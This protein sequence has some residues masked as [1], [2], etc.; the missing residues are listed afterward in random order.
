M[1]PNQI[2]FAGATLLTI[3][4]IA[5]ARQSSA[6]EDGHE[7]VVRTVD[8]GSNINPNDK[9]P[10]VR[11]ELGP[12]VP[13][14]WVRPGFK[15]STAIK[16][17]PGVRFLAFDDRGILY[18]SRPDEGDVIAFQA[19][20][21]GSYGQLGVFVSHR[22]KVQMLQFVN[23]WMWF[24]TSTGVSRAKTDSKGR[25]IDE[26]DIVPDGSLPGGSGHWWRSLFVTS[27]GFYTS[28]GDV[29]NITDMTNSPR[30][31]IWKYSLDGKQRQLWS[32]GIRNT[33]KLLYRPGTTEL[34]GC[35]QGSD[36]FGKAYG[37]R[38][39]Q[40]PITDYNPPDEFN[41]YVK[42][43][44][45][46]HP[47]VVGFLTPR[48]EYAD[49]ADIDQIAARTIPPEWGLGAHVAAD[50]WC[51]VEKAGQLPQDFVG[52]ALIAEHGSWNHTHK[53]GYRIERVLFDKVTGFPFGS[54]IL[55][56]CIT[57]NDQ[58]LARPV[59]VE[60]APDGSLLFT[61]DSDGR[62]Y[63]ISHA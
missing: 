23:G 42:G 51:F 28:V 37:D 16:G 29:G 14:F 7:R 47:F 2:V 15:V 57:D 8:V 52:D 46:G 21:D 22:P 39:G 54:Q 44:F 56:S 6:P 3:S 13:P 55:V 61:S 60:M 5:C 50:S 58:V 33:E 18:V 59:D 53:V 1:K 24:A 62:I 49:R 30:E 9:L 43:G 31:K 35:D 48:P 20:Q 32:S 19:N 40:Q 25:A 17:V 41:R 11:G 45:Y 36:W 27:D 26:V 38:E 63:R 4:I 10:S 34:W 12:G